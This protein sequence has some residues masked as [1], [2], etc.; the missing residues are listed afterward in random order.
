MTRV[1][2]VGATGYTG[3]ELVR[4]IAGHPQVEL[5]LLTS[6]NYAAE[7]FAAV[8]PAM[9]G[10]VD[11][12]CE[13]Y[14]V[15]RVC[16]SADF[17]FTALPHKLPMDIVPELLRRNKRVI[18]LSADFRFQDVS[19]YEAAYQEHSAPQLLPESIYGLPEIYADVIKTARLIGNPG[20]YPT[21]A[22]LALIPLLK[23]QCVEAD[24]LIID[25]KSGLSGA[26]RSASVATLFCEVNESFKA[27]KI[28]EHRHIPEMEAVLKQAAGLEVRLTFTPH[29]VPMSRG[30]LTTI[31]LQLKGKTNSDDIAH[32]L[33]SFYKEAPFVRILPHGTSADTLHVRG[34]NFCDIGFKVDERNRR[35]ILVSA[36]DNLVKGAAGQAVQNMN[37]MLGLDE[38]A[39]LAA[40]PYPV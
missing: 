39:G 7:R 18:D 22:L 40:V 36:I 14:D 35:L 11:L 6:R 10:V 12:T 20:C 31:Y 8:Y 4:I 21:S 24:M 15:D 13:A 32:A 27:Y 3:A 34:T 16:E 19:Q 38:R 17:I 37:I 28:A 33:N 1:C 25:A 23:A 26:G 30:M 5:S 9:A 2:I 29:L